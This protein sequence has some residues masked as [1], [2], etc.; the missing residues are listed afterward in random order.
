MAN[1][2]WIDVNDRMP[3]ARDADSTGRVMV[4]HTL[5]GV[6]MTGWHRLSEN[7]YITHWQSPPEGPDGVKNPEPKEICGKIPRLLL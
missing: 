3:E 2:G 4:W 5:N 7:R 1:S 6:M